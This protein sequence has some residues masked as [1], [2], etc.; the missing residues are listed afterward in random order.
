M[1][2]YTREEMPKLRLSVRVLS[3]G[4]LLLCCDVPKDLEAK[5]LVAMRNLL[6]MKCYRKGRLEVLIKCLR[7]STPT[8]KQERLTGFC[9]G[10]SRRSGVEILAQI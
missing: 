1:Y 10:L 5:I 7:N 6:Q 2:R 9:E 3:D 4:A 8:E